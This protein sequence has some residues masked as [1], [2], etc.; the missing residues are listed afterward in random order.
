MTASTFLHYFCV[1]FGGFC[2]YKVRLA[3]E[4]MVGGRFLD[5]MQRKL[6]VFIADSLKTTQP[7]GPLPI[8]SLAKY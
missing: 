1:I 4:K 7:P 8:T 5:I 2:W 3:L 6:L